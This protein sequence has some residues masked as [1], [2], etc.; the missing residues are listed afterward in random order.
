M[1]NLIKLV[2]KKGL[3]KSGG[4]K[5]KIFWQEKIGQKSRRTRAIFAKMHPKW[6]FF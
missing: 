1:Q 6:S 4:E 2:D 5:K 3:K